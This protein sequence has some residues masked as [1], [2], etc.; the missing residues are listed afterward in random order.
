MPKGLAREAMLRN[1][2]RLRGRPDLT[3]DVR[4]TDGFQESASADPGDYSR[5]LMN[6]RLAL[7]PRGATTETHRFF[8]ALKFG[9]IVLTDAVPPIWFYEQAPIVRLRHWDE[10]ERVAVPLL[11]DAERLETLHRE[12]LRWWEAACS[13][14]AVGRLMAGVLNAGA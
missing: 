7:V 9:C 1:V 6:S 5:A 14:E 12:A 3:V 8:Q 4:I 13:E 10:L 11:A 2:E